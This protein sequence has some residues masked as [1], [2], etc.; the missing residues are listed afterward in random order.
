MRIT[1]IYLDTKRGKAHIPLGIGYLASHLMHAGHEV[2]IMACETFHYDPGHILRK[3]HG[4]SANVFGITAMY[5]EIDLAADMVRKIKGI[6]QDATVILGGILPTT[7]PELSLQKTGA[8]IAVKGEAEITAA[9]LM[10]CLEHDP[11]SLS[12]VPGIVYR[13][14]DGE[15]IDTGCSKVANLSEILRPA[16]EIFPMD[17]TV[18]QFFYPQDETSRVA[19]VLASRGCPFS[20]NFCY[21]VSEPRYRGIPDVVEE[22]QYL[23][24]QYGV[25]TINFMDENFVLNKSRT[26]ELL[27]NIKSTGMDITFSAT[28][29]ASVITEEIVAWLYE[30]GCRTLNIGLESGDQ[31]ILDRM[32]KK[33]TVEQIVEA[34]ETA[35]RAGIFVE[36]PCMVGNLGETEESMRKTFQLLKQLAW[37]DFQWRFPFFCTPFPGTEIYQ[38]ALDKGLIRNDEDFYQ[39]YKSFY[40][41]SVNLTEIPDE[42]FLRLFSELFVDLEAYYYKQLPKWRPIHQMQRVSQR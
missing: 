41:L 28:A 17:R 25:D 26:E 29:R 8:D 19:D 18:S 42:D 5:P 21:N 14:E 2:D 11:Q 31:A 39:K 9:E 7:V 4:S 13:G 38:Y 32:G 40:T 10:D 35:R 6:R 34:I 33:I 20:C 37:G 30:A 22:I 1:L 12:E 24:D 15:F 36:Y 16:Y 27:E 23:I 3:I